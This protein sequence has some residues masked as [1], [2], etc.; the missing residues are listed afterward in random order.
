MKLYYFIAHN[1]LYKVISNTSL[2]ERWHK[3]RGTQISRYLFTLNKWKRLHL[4][5]AMELKI[6]MV[7]NYIL[8][9]DDE[10]V[11]IILIG[12]S[13]LKKYRRKR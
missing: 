13:E 1:S 3:E 12:K 5:S 4:A 7:K 11:A 6:S 8:L 10:A 9:T 2:M